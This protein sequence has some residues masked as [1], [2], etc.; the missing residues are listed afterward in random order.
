MMN[1]FADL[2]FS[3]PVVAATPTNLATLGIEIVH[4]FCGELPGP[5]PYIKEARMPAGSFL[6]KHSH[7]HDHLSVLVSGRARLWT[8]GVAEEHAGYCSLF[9]PAGV[10]HGIEAVTD[11]IWL[12]VW[13]TDDTD[14]ATVDETIMKG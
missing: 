9:M 7:L 11:C 6:G 1:G 13:A 4:H 5:K 14:P 8:K 3:G 2:V 12:C 10:E